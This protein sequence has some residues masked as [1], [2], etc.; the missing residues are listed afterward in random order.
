VEI[1]CPALGQEHLRIGFAERGGWLVAAIEQRGWLKDLADAPLQALRTALAGLYKLA[2]VHLVREEI[3]ACFNGV[4]LSFDIGQRG[5]LVWL[6]G[7]CA[8]P[9]VYDLAGKTR[10]FPHS[11]DGTRQETLPV[12]AA[13]G[14]L[15][16][17]LPL[18]WDRWV[19]A[20]EQDQFGK[21]QGCGVLQDF[22]LL[23]RM[24][25]RD[26]PARE[27]VATPGERC[28]EGSR[29]NGASYDRYAG[30]Q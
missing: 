8:A 19:A 29:S 15:Y 1:C 12:L 16:H 22:Q 9:A 17:M 18:T 21:E 24:D 28:F 6:N 5:L 13:A 4:L 25:G 14:V 11:M 10:V 27:P 30:A 7:D 3:E 20:W 2:G 23:P 26:T